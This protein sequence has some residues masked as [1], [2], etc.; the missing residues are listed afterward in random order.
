MTHNVLLPKIENLPPEL[1]EDVSKYID[2]LLFINS[3]NKKLD[4]I[5][6]G[7]GIAKNKISISENFNEPI[8][9]IFEVFK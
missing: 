4:V 3:K 8:E 9:E 1:L 5:T 2:Y 7:F 6:N